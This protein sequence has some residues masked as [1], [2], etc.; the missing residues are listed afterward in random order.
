MPSSFTDMINAFSDS[1]AA[2]NA[3]GGSVGSGH[4]YAAAVSSSEAAD[5]AVNAVISGLIEAVTPASP[6]PPTARAEALWAALSGTVS[7]SSAFKITASTL[8]TLTTGTG[9]IA[10][11]VNA[12]NLGSMF[13]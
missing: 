2:Y 4:V 5:I 12:S 6:A 10:N 1:C 13:K 7:P 9:D 8:T 11:L 3:L